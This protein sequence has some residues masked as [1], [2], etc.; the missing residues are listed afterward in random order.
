MVPLSVIDAFTDT[1]FG[2]NPAAVCLLPGVP[3]WPSD[4]WL[5][6]VAAEMNL[7]ETAFLKHREGC[8]YELRWFTPA[9]E[10]ALCGHATLAAAHFLWE[11]GRE[12]GDLLV[13]LTRRRGLLPARRRPSGEIELDFPAQ[14]AT[15][16]T[17]PDGL[18]TALGTTAVTVGR[19]ADDFLVEVAS[20]TAVRELRPDFVALAAIDCRGVIVTAASDEPRFD[21]VSRFFGPRA[22]V[23]EDPVTGSAHCCLAEYW[24]ERFGRA[25]LTGYQAS[26]RGGVVR[27]SR[28]GGRVK[29]I[30]R[31]VAMTRGQ[32]AVEPG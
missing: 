28:G 8:E 16:C 20:A 22:G 19:N 6:S 3:P 4:E 14:P 23:N 10:V 31:A 25:E 2:G 32:L 9:V 12:G 27:V 13:F 7:S 21:F 18:L 17:P 24:G 1:A 11:A 29:L 5:Q 26:A 30:G 15:A